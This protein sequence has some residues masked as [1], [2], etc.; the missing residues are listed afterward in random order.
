MCVGGGGGEGGDGAELVLSA[1]SPI[2]IGCSLNR[3][4]HGNNY[5]IY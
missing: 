1:S 4:L 2:A 3:F 5:A